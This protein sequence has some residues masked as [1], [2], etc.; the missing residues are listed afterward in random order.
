[1]TNNANT[2]IRE[3]RDINLPFD[4][5]TLP[6]SKCE[7][8]RREYSYIC[9]CDHCLSVSYRFNTRAFTLHH[10]V[11]T[12][13]MLYFKFQKG[14]EPMRIYNLTLSDG[15]KTVWNIALSVMR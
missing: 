8:A 12:F 15:I 11:V 13:D 2:S 7:A 9:R 10:N 3:S 4:V 1:M 5:I 6:R 14:M